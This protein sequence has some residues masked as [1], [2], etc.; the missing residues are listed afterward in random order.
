MRD[1]GRL[2]SIATVV[3]RRERA[4]GGSDVAV[5]AYGAVLAALVV[6][7]PVLRA[8]VLALAE[9]PVAASLA[10]SGAAGI[11]GIV[12]IV[13]LAGAA[14][15]GPVRGPAVT[16]PTIAWIVASG[17]LPRRAVL[18]R[19]V[20]TAAIALSAALTVVVALVATALVLAGVWTPS[21]AATVL[22]GTLLVGVVAA[23]T[24]LI[25]QRLPPRGA[26]L[27]PCAI[28][29]LG[30]LGLAFEPV[31]RLLPWG[32]LE[33]LWRSAGAAGE[34]AWLDPTIALAVA[35]VIGAVA[36]PWLLDGL[37]GPELVRQAA[38]WERVGTAVGAL[39]GAGAVGE[40]R[41]SPTIGRTWRAVLPVPRPFVIP[42]ADAI[43]AAR[44]PVVA[45]TGVLVLVAS[46]LLLALAPAGPPVWMLVG[47][48]ALIGQTSLA[49][50]LRDA[51]STLLGPPVFGGPPLRALA[52]H[53]TWPFV[54]GTIVIAATAL[55]TGGPSWHLVDALAVAACATGAIAME[56]VKGPLPVAL[57]A[58][59]PTAFG[60]VSV[61]AVAAWQL[62]GPILV[63]A[64]GAIGGALATSDPR[65]GACAMLA[66]ALL[67]VA[68]VAWRVRV[69]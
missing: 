11:V 31:R 3:R 49:T 54:A 24:W 44:R 69:P 53:A 63:L 52:A 8:V 61:F 5:T 16:T 45:L 15:L 57:L 13:V 4:R 68:V 37:A 18:G 19:A 26:Q 62:D 64:S 33:T 48:G 22:V 28:A 23:V 17:P 56:S 29:A 32:A 10:T 58:P 1:A 7:V 38:R 21:G 55:V 2:R 51:G 46:G 65:L 60:D 66:G 50:G 41:A 14:A 42:L 34:P 12:T 36:I 40:L 6:G 35:A 39:D 43:G 67:T 27:A 25:G 20:T 9:Q 30:L 59:V 47:L